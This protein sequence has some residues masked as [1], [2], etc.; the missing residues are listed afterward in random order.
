MST[1]QDKEF[2]DFV[3]DQ[4]RGMSDLRCR[5]MFGGFGLYQ[6][7][8]FFG[9]LYDARLFLKVDDASRGDF[10]SRGMGPFVASETQTL[11]SYYETPA[12]VI[13]SPET[14]TRWAERAVDAQRNTKRKPRRST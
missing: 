1:G 11:R 6:G 8:H 14:L 2:R 7:E 12:E 5:S 4:L 3:L 9:I 13:E 10:E